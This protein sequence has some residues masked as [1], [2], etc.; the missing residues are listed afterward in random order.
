MKTV[1]RENPCETCPEA[2]NGSFGC[3]NYAKEPDPENPGGPWRIKGWFD[4]DEEE[5]MGRSHKD[6]DAPIKPT[7]LRPLLNDPSEERAV[8]EGPIIGERL[9][10]DAQGEGVSPDHIPAEQPP[11]GD[12]PD[13]DSDEEEGSAHAK[14]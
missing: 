5:R 13:L 1:A 6:R 9:D 4:C 11:T 8:G 10:H 3:Y 7:T 2:W 12:G 14:S